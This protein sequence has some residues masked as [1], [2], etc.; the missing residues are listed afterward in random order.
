M[1]AATQRRLAAGLGPATWLALLLAFSAPL[2]AAVGT[3]TPLGPEG[4]GGVKVAT[5]PATPGIVYAGMDGGLFR[6]VDGAA[7]WT[8]ATGLPPGP[9]SVTVDPLDP[10]HVYAVQSAFGNTASFFSSHDRGVTWTAGGAFGLPNTFIRAVAADPLNAA[11]VYAASFELGLFRSTDGGQSWQLRS[12]QPHITSLVADSQGRIFVGTADNI[13]SFLV[14]GDG[15]ATWTDKSDGLPRIGDIYGTVQVVL[16]PAHRDTLYLDAFR[17]LS[18]PGNLWK[19][20]DGGESWAALGAHGTPISIAPDGTIYTGLQRSTDGGAS[21]TALGSFPLPNRDVLTS[22]AFDAKSPGTLFALTFIDGVFVSHDQGASWTA[23]S[24]RL[25][26][27]SIS[28]VAVSP[29]APSIVYASTQGLGFFRARASGRTWRQVG[30]HESNFFTLLT[31]P[32]AAQTLYAF[33]PLQTSTD[34]GASWQPLGALPCPLVG[35]QLSLA[36]TQPTTIY[37]AQVGLFAGC[38]DCRIARSADG[39]ATWTCIALGAPVIVQEVVA[40][41]SR[42]STLYASDALALWKSTDSGAHWIRR[43]PRIPAR[44]FSLLAVDPISPDVVFIASFSKLFESVNGGRRWFQIGQQLPSGP[45]S[46]RIDPRD[47]QSLYA[48]VATTS[49]LLYHSA[50]GGRTWTE[51]SIGLPF[52]SGAFAIDLAHPRTVFAGTSFNGVQSYTLPVP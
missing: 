23:A 28:A 20:T 35:Y 32:N 31:D 29:L 38:D 19:S 46:L 48:Q 21:W 13:S 30:P 52:F 3:W 33:F 39:G 7:S 40:A 49:E 5:D 10:A 4:G 24:H 1:P 34:G 11:T 50:D 43:R 51:I 18:E 15:G 14:S 12:T 16:D 9:M 26:S 22:M 41:P 45:V 2:A 47:P 6:S 42:P 36:P 37:L 8:L 17:I 44:G 27:T 25:F